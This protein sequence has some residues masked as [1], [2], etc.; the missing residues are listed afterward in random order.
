MS[1]PYYSDDLVTLYHGDCRDVLPG[2]APGSVDVLL[3]DPPYF[4]VKDEEWDRQWK[5]RDDFLGWLGGVLDMAK[6]LLKPSASVWVFASPFMARAVEDL[7]GDR[8]RVLNSIR[9]V[10]EAGWHN[11]AEV[12]TQRRYLTPWEAV[13][14]AEQY[15]DAY[16]EQAH[17]LHKQVFAPIGR[18]LAQE[19]ERAGLTRSQVE[20]ALGYASRSD[21]TR[22]T[23]LC[24]RWEE[25]SS[26]PTAEAYGKLRVLLGDGYLD[27]EYEDLRREY[28]DLRREYEDLRREYEDLRRPFRLSDRGPVSDLWTFPPVM[29]YPGKHPCEKPLPMIR[30]MI[31]T[32]SRAGALILDPF[33]GSGATL[34]ACKELGRRCIG[35]EIEQ[36]YCKHAA[37]RLSQD[38]LMFGEAS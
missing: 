15:D 36:R 24:Y 12:E 13:V 23:A 34:R 20:V 33:A 4:Q 35:I 19:R 11:K 26:L 27:R 30:H 7:V 31:E 32:S 2:V 17:A 8:F 21:P 16:G 38:L 3:T 25:G 18:Y 14:L 22:G 9:W 6:P 1:A 29:G 10:K 5:K 37:L 28:E